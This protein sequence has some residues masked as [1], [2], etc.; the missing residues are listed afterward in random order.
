MMV[1]HGS[2]Y[3]G[4]YPGTTWPGYT[5]FFYMFTEMWNR[6]Q[7]AWQHFKDTL[8]YVGRN[9][10]ILQKGVPRVDIAFY[11]FASPWQ[12][13]SRYPSTNLQDLGM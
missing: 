7:P 9:Q 11:L 13:A 5:T 10:L 3:S 4:D 6:I 8:E 2:P 12:P 1:I